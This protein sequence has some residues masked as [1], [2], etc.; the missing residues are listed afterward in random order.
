[1]EMMM[2]MLLEW[3]CRFW[4]MNM[5]LEMEMYNPLYKEND[6]NPLY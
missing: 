5:L 6:D 3:K 1:M 2:N 4:C